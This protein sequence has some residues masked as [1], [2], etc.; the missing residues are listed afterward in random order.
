M[1]NIFTFPKQNKTKQNKKNSCRSI[2]N[3]NSQHQKS[4]TKSH[5]S[6]ISVRLP[7]L[8]W[9]ALCVDWLI[10]PVEAP[11]HIHVATLLSVSLLLLGALFG[12]VLWMGMEM[13]MKME[14]SRCWHWSLSKEIHQ[15]RR[16]HQYCCLS[17]RPNDVPAFALFQEHLLL[18]LSFNF[19]FMDGSILFINPHDKWIRSELRFNIY[20]ITQHTFN[21]DE[22]SNF[23]IFKRDINPFSA[24]VMYCTNS[25]NSRVWGISDNDCTTFFWF[26]RRGWINM[27]IIDRSF[28]WK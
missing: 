15:S 27:R 10:G 9:L 6:S 5:I 7:I 25:G 26:E 23:F 4:F 28:K 2:P 16:T 3:K 14:M 17:R 8:F 22:F 12:I 24:S 13:K 19:Q 1:L 11:I 20:F 18:F 21:M